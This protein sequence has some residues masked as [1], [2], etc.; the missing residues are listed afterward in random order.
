MHVNLCKC[1]YT[2]DSVYLAEFTCFTR[3]HADEYL[4][5]RDRSCVQMNKRE[6][7]TDP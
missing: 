1:T 6:L 4:G 2:V 3:H 5:Q 7:I